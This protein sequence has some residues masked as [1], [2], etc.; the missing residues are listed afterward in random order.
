MKKLIFII[1]FFTIL[2]VSC[3]KEYVIEGHKIL[4][5]HFSNAKTGEP[6]DSIFCFI[7]QPSWIY[8]RIVTDTFS[9]K[10]GNC[11]LEVDYKS[12]D[13]YAFV[14]RED[15]TFNGNKAFT[16]RGNNILEKYRAKGNRPYINF[17]KQNDFD[18]NI[19][20]IPLIRLKIIYEFAKNYNGYPTLEIFENN[21][22]IYS[23]CKGGSYSASERDSTDCYV[24]SVIQTKLVYRYTSNNGQII[25]SKSL[26]IDPDLINNT[27]IHLLFN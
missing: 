27:T 7:G 12:S 17:G 20:L 9:D 25:F 3:K 16:Y 21:E 10:N 15:L 8:Y 4:N 18:L 26:V 11:K 19:Q 22:S 2:F 14:I 5:I 24:S 6:I 13:K 23:I 1:S